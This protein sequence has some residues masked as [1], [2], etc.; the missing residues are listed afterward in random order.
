MGSSR[1]SKE[2]VGIMIFEKLRDIIAEQFGIDADTITE[3]TSFAEDLNADSL[4]MVDMVLAI[5]DQ[6]NIAEI[7][8][9]ELAGIETVGQVVAL[10]EAKA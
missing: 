2:R 1:G 7:D 6:F 3:G 9:E 4:D 8:D 10:I 5:Q